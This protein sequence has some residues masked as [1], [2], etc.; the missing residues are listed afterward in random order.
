MPYLI[1]VTKDGE[2]HVFKVKGSR[3]SAQFKSEDDALDV[4]ES[5]VT[6]R[7]ASCRIVTIKKPP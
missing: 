3:V 6:E 4:C 2:S 7:G 1:I 5:L